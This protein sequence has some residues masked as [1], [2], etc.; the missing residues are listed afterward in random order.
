MHGSPS[1]EIVKLSF[2]FLFF[3]NIVSDAFVLLFGLV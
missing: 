1:S 3:L 2:M